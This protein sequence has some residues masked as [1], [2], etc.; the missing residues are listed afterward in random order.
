MQDFYYIG[1]DM[2]TTNIKVCAYNSAAEELASAARRCDTTYP[3]PDSAEQRPSQWWEN[4]VSAVQEISQAVGNRV[5][6]TICI[7]SHVPAIVP[8][9]QEGT[10]LCPAMIWQDFRASREAEALRQDLGPRLA[11]NNPAEPLPYHF[12]SKLAWFMEHRPDIYEKTWKFLQPK[13]YLTLHL[14]GRAVW[15]ESQ[16]GFNHLFKV[17]ERQLDPE[18]AETL[19]PGLS[20]K[21]PEVVPSSA[22]IGTVLPQIADLL[23]ISRET[24][25]FAGGTDTAAAVLGS[26]IFHPGEVAISLGTGANI[27]MTCRPETMTKF[28]N[29]VS[30]VRHVAGDAYLSICTTTNAGN[31]LDWYMDNLAQHYV[32]R[33]QAGEGSRYTL[34]AADAAQSPPGCS[35]VLFL[36]YLGGE[37]VPIFD[38]NARGSFFGLSAATNACDLARA[39]LESMC[40]SVRHALEFLMENCG[41]HTLNSVNVSGGQTKMPLWMQILADV[42]QLRVEIYTEITPAPRG[43][44]II[45]IVHTN[46]GTAYDSFKGPC[47]VYEPDPAKRE[48][49][50]RRFAQYKALYQNLKGLFQSAFSSIDGLK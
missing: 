20:E 50:D 48:I 44:A 23:G 26:N 46:P 43:N 37:T 29:Q 33:E 28:S 7:S 3:E 12:I 10:A 14:T 40:Y 18:L 45:G 47:Q 17:L 13:D 36:P 49:Y 21:L 32:T 6:R 41:I 16:C 4:F 31:V 24:L 30:F 1:A 27:L 5:C 19:R 8:V 11:Q 38:I 39:V 34:V 22:C 25:V 15:D 42:L 2:G 35:G 9:G